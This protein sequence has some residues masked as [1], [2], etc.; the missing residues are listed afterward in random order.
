[1][2]K[3]LLAGSFAAAVA[4]SGAANAADM[5]VKAVYKAPIAVATWSWDGWYVGAHVGYSWGKWDSTCAFSTQCFVSSPGSFSAA[6]PAGNLAAVAAFNASF[7]NTASPAVN[8][9]VGGVH[10]GRNWQFHP[11]WVVGGEVDFDVTG[12]RR[13]QDAA[14]SV[15]V[16]VGDSRL[17]LT[18]AIANEW[19]FNW[20]STARG[21]LGWASDR[22]LFYATGG[23]AVG[24]VSYS[25]TATSTAIQTTLGGTVLAGPVTTTLAAL[26]QKQVRLGF[27]VGGGYERAFTDNIIGRIEYLYVDLGRHTFFANSVGGFDTDVRL[28][29]HIVRGALSYKFNEAPIVARY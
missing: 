3:I 1:M 2:K 10:A 6:T 16:I 21:R 5:P 23:L 18:Q 13:A 11:N 22:S 4:F 28:R 9:W 20:F 24:E 14:V 17:T 27:A 15:S 8:G 26:S 19:K 29:D 12:E 7:T 25:T